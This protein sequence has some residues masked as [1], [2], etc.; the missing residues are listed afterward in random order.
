[1]E[2]FV[3]KGAARSF[4]EFI[5]LQMS[6]CNWHTDCTCTQLAEAQ[7]WVILLPDP[8]LISAWMCLGDP[9]MALPCIAVMGLTLASYWTISS[10][11]S[12]QNGEEACSLEMNRLFSQSV[13]I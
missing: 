9:L 8:L 2:C 5:C 6:G 13:N 1:M 4:K 7:R 10:S 11:F 12:V 3:D